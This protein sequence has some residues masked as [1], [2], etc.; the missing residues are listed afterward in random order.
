MA[1][2][3]QLLSDVDYDNLPDGAEDQF[4]SL[5]SICRERL[6]KA[7]AEVSSTSVTEKLKI[8]YMTHV[9]AAAEQ[10]G[11]PPLYQYR[12]RVNP[13]DVFDQFLESV[14]YLIT[15]MNLERRSRNNAMSVQLSYETKNA[16]EQ[17][18][19]R[20]RAIIEKS[21]LSE[22]QKKSLL[23]KLDEL[24]AELQQP[25]FSFWKAMAIIGSI[26]MGMQIG[27]SFLADAPDAIAT[28]ASLIAA[29]K[30]AEDEKIRYLRPPPKPLALP[31]PEA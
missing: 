30:E 17:Q 4:L 22:D 7:L 10:L 23:K 16:I 9:A 11:L 26:S 19:H 1:T 5:Q 21:N 31:A 15:Q 18:V 28:I 3:H 13:A 2:D 25:R 12:G 27:A 24:L 20:L 14:D 8:Q 29:D 6:F